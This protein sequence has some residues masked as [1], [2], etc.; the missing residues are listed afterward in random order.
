M[1]NQGATRRVDVKEFG[2]MLKE[3]QKALLPDGFT[4]LESAAVQHNIRSVSNMYHN[5]SLDQLGTLLGLSEAKVESLA[6]DMISEGRLRG[7]IDQARLFRFF[8]FVL[9]YAGLWVLHL[10]AS[11]RDR[12][13]SRAS[14]S[15]GSASGKIGVPD[16]LQWPQDS[17]CFF[18]KLVQEAWRPERIKQKVLVQSAHGYLNSSESQCVTYK[19]CCCEAWAHEQC[20]QGTS[21]HEDCTCAL[22]FTI[23]HGEAIASHFTGS[24]QAT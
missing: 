11:P 21:V 24:R 15:Q 4:V 8:H 9:F 18:S 23:E 10:V 6:C 19:Q 12:C 7:H 22:H 20:K 1:P 17:L 16:N 13:I 5:I 14:H 2:S 3:H